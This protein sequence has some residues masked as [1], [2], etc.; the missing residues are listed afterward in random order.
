MAATRPAHDIVSPILGPVEVQ[1]AVV[2]LQESL[3]KLQFL[4][5]ITPDVMQHR[6]E[7][8]KFVGEEISRTL[9][10]QRGLE[11]RYE[12][13]ISFRASLK[14]LVNKT[15]YKELQVE[16]QDVSRAL[17]EST[18][19]LCRNLKDNPN[20]AGNL[21]KIQRESADLM[22]ILSKTIRELREKGTFNTVINRVEQDKAQKA[23]LAKIIQEEKETTSAVQQI[24]FDIRT[25]GSKHDK[26]VKQQ[27]EKIAK[28]KEELLAIKYK[29]TVDTKYLRR[30]ATS[31]SAS[32]YRTYQQEEREL[33]NEIKELTN[34]H[35]M[36]V[37]VHEKTKDFLK[38]KHNMLQNEKENWEKKIESDYSKLDEEFQNLKSKRDSNFE[39]LEKLRKRRQKEL[40]SELE[41]KAERLRIEEV[42]R[43]KAEFAGRQNDACIVIQKQFRLF[44]KWK[45]EEAAKKATG[46]KK[47]KK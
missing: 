34:R 12:E 43:A 40:Q 28:L 18:K 30:E 27:K 7:L 13:L 1:R 29:T 44:L 32:I 46:K 22:D 39:K 41:D 19:N 5:T 11:T 26:E 36:E 6:D 25:E 42:E 2:T 23:R 17:R 37:L 21:L 3:E 24:E 9:K 14:G 4:G 35:E 20:I 33:E 10:E 16:I 45:Q 15:K 47:K 8:S 31:K 38:K